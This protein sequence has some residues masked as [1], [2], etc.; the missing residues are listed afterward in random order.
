MDE[1]KLA[2][3]HAGDTCLLSLV[4][5]CIA[6]YTWVHT[7]GRP[8][9]MPGLQLQ[10]PADVL[11]NF[12]GFTHPTFRGAGLQSRRHEAVLQQR[13]WADRPVMMGYVKAT[14]FASRKGQTRSGY[15]KIGSVVVLG[16]RGHFL[17]WLSPALRRLGMRRLDG[18]AAVGRRALNRLQ[19]LL[20]QAWVGLVSAT[21]GPWLH[22]RLLR[23]SDRSDH[24]TYTCFHRAPTQ[25]QALSGPVLSHLG[26]DRKPGDRRTR[27]LRVLLYACSNGAEAYTL[28]AWLAAQ[29]PDLE[30][31]IEASDLHPDMVDRA[32]AGRYSWAELAQHH[33][34]PAWFVAQVFDREG[35]DYVVNERTRSRVRF[36]CADIVRDDLRGRFGQADVVLAQNVLFHLPPALAR[37][38]FDNVISTLAPTGAL[39]IEGMDPDLRMDLTTENGLQPLAWRSRDIYIES[40]KHIPACWWQ[41]YYGAEPWLP[42]RRDPLRR[43]GSIF[44]QGPVTERSWA[45]A[46]ALAA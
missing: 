7:R 38:A 26:L 1:A 21:A 14:N 25:L 31:L 8:Q 11:Y 13:C 35:E 3:L 18:P 10:L 24:H 2:L 34:V 4:D 30:V 44:L 5:G 6:G 33:Q 39:F 17:T 32:R 28:S 9:I 22:R 40:R 36:S 29:R 23:H 27:S 20:R 42:W 43:Y 45:R 16:T 15:R 12:A 46:R 19:G 41:V 37:R